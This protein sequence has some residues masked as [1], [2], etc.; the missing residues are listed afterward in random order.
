M[1][2]VQSSARRA[3]LSSCS[4]NGAHATY[5]QR[6]RQDVIYEFAQPDPPHMS[7]L[8]AGILTSSSRQARDSLITVLYPCRLWLWAY[9]TIRQYAHAAACA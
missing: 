7:H 5:T 4:A 2:S 3:A 6:R 8:L 1:S 9:A